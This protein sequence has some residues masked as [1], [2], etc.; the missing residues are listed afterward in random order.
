MTPP[1]GT[2]IVGSRGSQLALAQ[3]EWVIDQMR[4]HHG[5]GF[6]IEVIDS[7]PSRRPGDPSLGDGIFVREIQKSLLQKKV[8]VAVHSLKDLPTAPMPGLTIAAIPQR[9]DPREALVGGTL[10]SLPQGA[11]VGTSS[12]RRT[13]QLRRLRPDLEVVPLRGNIP[14]RIEKIR[15]GQFHAAMLAAAGLE[16]LGIPA[17]EVLDPSAALPAPG[18]G[19]LAVEVREMDPEIGELVARIQDRDTLLAVMAE[20]AVLR[21]LGG[22]CLVPIS[23]YGKVSGDVLSLE[24]SV[25]SS[26]GKAEVRHRAEGSPE[27]PAG[28]AA[29]V[30]ETLKSAGALELLNSR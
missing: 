18:Q 20:R 16:R 6:L 15:S 2:L 28:L 13:A 10:Q 19:A 1:P 12:P 17:D 30:A 25:T 24:A 11:R 21:E 3:T 23:A 27:N 26:D 5:T 8:D 9:A 22:G 29:E 7:R 14:T 4:S